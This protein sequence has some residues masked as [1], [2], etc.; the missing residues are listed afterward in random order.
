VQLSSST[1]R[2]ASRLG[3]ANV[4]GCRHLPWAV[5]DGQSE[6]PLVGGQA[7]GDR[8]R[9][10]YLLQAGGDLGVVQVGVSRRI[11]GR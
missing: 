8:V 9:A 1:P 4:T 6:V 7:L 11:H 3:W 10:A 5:T 2:S